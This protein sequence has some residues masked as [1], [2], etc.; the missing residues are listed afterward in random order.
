MRSIRGVIHPAYLRTLVWRGLILWLVTRVVVSGLTALIPPMGFFPL[1]LPPLSALLLVLTVAALAHAD[2]RALR[3]PIFYA[4][5][6][7]PSWLPA[8]V[9][10]S[11]V[12]LLELLIRVTVAVA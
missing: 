6:G 11:C 2:A 10:G 9:A 7:T 1:V 3:E 8:M 12:L 5:L 4:N